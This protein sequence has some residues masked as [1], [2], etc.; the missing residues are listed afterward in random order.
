MEGVSEPLA[1]RIEYEVC[2]AIL[3][4]F[5]EPSRPSR[6]VPPDLAGS[7][8]GARIAAL[9]TRTWIELAEDPEVARELWLEDFHSL[10]LDC[11]HYFLPGFLLTVIRHPDLAGVTNA[12]IEILCP[13]GGSLLGFGFAERL[14]KAQK[15]AVANWFGLVL[16]RARQSPPDYYG[17]K[18]VPPHYERAFE[19]WKAWSTLFLADGSF[20][21]A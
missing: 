18:R 19:Q 9:E 1:G 10:T 21:F 12:M 16:H 5:R 4:A 2:E 3:A 20:A 13:A 17:E 11:F 6:C 14:T 15:N 8:E 7:D